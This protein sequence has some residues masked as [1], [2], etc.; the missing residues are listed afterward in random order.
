MRKILL[1]L[2]LFV[3][4][5]TMMARQ[6]TPDEALALA[7]GKMKAAQPK[8]SKAQAAGINAAS[9]S[10]T[11]TEMTSQDVPLMYVY[12]IAKGGFIIASADDRVSSLLGY[13]DS[14]DFEGA[15]QNESFMAWL[16]G[17]SKALSSIS[18]MPEHMRSASAGTRALTTSVQP[19]LGETKWDQGAPY[20]LLTPMR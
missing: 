1:L 5:G 12:N 3:L 16:E 18:S 13:T 14:G 6:L 17:C 8:N 7:M 9:V 19:L 15:K 4:A 11:H 20:N 2:T 10:L